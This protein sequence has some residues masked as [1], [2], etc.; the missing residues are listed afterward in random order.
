MIKV[1]IAGAKGRVGQLLVEE[2][3][4]GVWDGMQFA[5]GMDRGDDAR[6]LFEVADVVIEFSVPEATVEHATI[7]AQTGTAYVACTTGLDKDQEAV[8]EK[9]AQDIP[10]VYASNTSL[11]VNVLFALV[12]QAARYLPDYD[13]EV[14]E[15]HHN[16][17]VDAP[18]GTALTLGKTAAAAR[19]VAFDDVAQLSREGQVGVRKPGEIGF[20]TVRGGDAVGEHTVSL[21]GMGE[22]LEIR[23]QA[24]DRRLYAQGA[25]RAA[26][27]VASQ[28]KGLYSMRD[29]LGL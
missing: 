2:L 14:I 23:Q 27:W 11:A 21:F 15:A 4:S 7:A 25:L 12:E 6:G 3:E 17:K 13:I 19:G 8:L 9:A 1:G 20:A 29:V 18:S 10:L 16:K 28:P 26:Q 5:G 22:R 24:T